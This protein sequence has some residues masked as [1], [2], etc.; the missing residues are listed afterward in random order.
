VKANGE[1]ISTI[2]SLRG[3]TVFARPTNMHHAN[4]DSILIASSSFALVSRQPPSQL[5]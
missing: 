3:E 5:E 2:I 4:F 1:I